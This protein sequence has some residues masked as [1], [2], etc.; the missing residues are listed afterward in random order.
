MKNLLLAAL[1][2]F[3]LISCGGDAQ[4]LPT[5]DETASVIMF[6]PP[7]QNTDNTPLT[8]LA[9][10]KVY[11]KQLSGGTYTD[12]NSV[13]FNT[14]NATQ[15]SLVSL[16]IVSDGDY[17][18]VMTAFNMAGAESS[19]FSNAATF[20]VRGG[21]LYKNLTSGGAPKMVTGV[22]IQ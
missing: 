9:G 1:L 8:D 2:A 15:V 4:S 16:G 20:Y 11:W 3:T 7:T 19:S 10:Y 12:A 14:P 13:T 18:V 17:S 22:T 6:T 5:A 21:Q